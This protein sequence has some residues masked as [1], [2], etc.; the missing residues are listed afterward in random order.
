MFLWY[1]H[2]QPVDSQGKW[3]EW[4]SIMTERKSA[5]E[6][7]IDR[8][9]AEEFECEPG[10]VAD[11][12][13][14]TAPDLAGLLVEKAIPEPKLSEGGFGDLLI[15]GRIGDAKVALLIEDKIT[16]G[17]TF[18]QA[19]RYKLHKDHLL[20]NGYS[21]VSTLLVAPRGYSGE[22]AD[23]EHFLALEDIIPLLRNDSPKRLRF[24]RDILKRAITKKNTSGVRLH[25]EGTRQLREAY[26]RQAEAISASHDI[27]L[28]FPPLRQKVYDGDSWIERIRH[29]MLPRDIELRH[30]LWTT[31]HNPKGRID[32]I[33]RAPTT[34]DIENARSAPP[35][36][37][38]VENFSK[39]GLQVSLIM[40]EIRPNSEVTTEF[41]ES[42]VQKMAALVEWYMV[43]GARP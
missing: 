37:A 10:F 4:Q 1:F 22:S 27:P 13:Q 29:P 30:R 41:I 42:A 9:L 18:R 32:L 31:L 39:S 16:A 8:L 34:D 40:D 7:E 3:Q 6:V 26:T 11:F 24:R 14:H 5:Q 2:R 15:E 20:R 19:E 38:I 36:D 35:V 23:Y 28:I 33:F 12:I 43:G 25:D 21:A 17:P